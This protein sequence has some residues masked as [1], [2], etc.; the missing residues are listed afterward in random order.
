MEISVIIPVYNGGDKLQKCVSALQRQKTSRTYELIIVDDGSTDEGIKKIKENGFRVLR[1]A[2]QGPAAARN[3]GVA[4]ANG[5]IVL[6]TDADCE[7]EEDWIEQMVHALEDSSISGVKGSYLTRQKKIVPRFVQYE[8]ESKYDRMKKDPYIDFIDTYAAGFKK[9]EFLSVGA[10]DTRFSTASVED[11]EFSFRMWEKG[12]RMVFNPAARVYHTHSETLG[13]YTK[14]KFRIGFWKALVLKRHPKKIARDSHTPQSL[15]LEMVFAML[16]LVSLLLSL[17]N[18]NF[19]PYALFPLMGFLAT[20]SPFIVKLFWLDPLV[21][22]FSPV[23]LFVRAVSLSF[24]LIVGALKFYVLDKSDG[25]AVELGY[26]RGFSR[27]TSYQYGKGVITQCLQKGYR[28][29]SL[30]VFWWS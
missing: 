11:Q 4:N 10:Y 3:L 21:A 12:C 13:N 7:P 6:F 14:K 26:Q 20:S 16:F 25:S 29:L 30:L 19:L 9:N 23:L 2:N 28:I 8:Y 1:Q 5:K 22:L 15:K 17:L 24:G 18:N 27:T